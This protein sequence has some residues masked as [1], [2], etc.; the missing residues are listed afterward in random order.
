MRSF[1]VL[2]CFCAVAYAQ[3]GSFGQ[4][5]GFQQN[6]RFGSS[7]SSFS[8]QQSATNKQ[9]GSQPS[10]FDNQRG[11]QPSAFGNQRGSQPSAFGNQRGSQ[12]SA[13]GG[14]QNRYQ[15]PQQSA[16]ASQPS[17]GQ[18]AG[19]CREKNERSPVPGS[20]DRYIECING[21]AE[22]KLCPD[23]LL[24]NSN[25]N[26]NVY[27]CQYPN[28]VQCLER[29]SLQPPQPTED[30]P[31]QFGYFKL[32]DARNCSGFRTCVNGVGYDL[33][34][35]EGLAFSS[36]TYRCEWPDT[37]AD[38]DA[39]AFLGFRCP[40]VPISKELGA[41]AGY[42]FYRSDVNCQK[43]FLCID[44]RPRVLGCGGDNAFDELT[45]SCVSADEVAACPNE[46]KAAAARS[47]EDEKQRL[48]K[49]LTVKS[50]P[51]QK[52]RF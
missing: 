21:T 38:C 44:G 6:S 14:T 29:S 15:Q 36:E 17:R 46:L 45:S 20:C 39:E 22:E 8:N 2:A 23:G 37:V 9:R 30:C 34:C 25:V 11:S 51:Q 16:F 48:A 33:T 13:F 1:I 42:R 35:P 7:Q 50:S 19:S 27:P 12:Q 47:R 4:N 28:E 40:D 49:E 32:G 10:A 26:F 24:F 31:H 18:S 5:S 43:Y 41:P 52:R 3:F